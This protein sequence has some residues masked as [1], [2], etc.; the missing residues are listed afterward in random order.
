[1]WKG[2]GTT[3]P[4]ISRVNRRDSKLA[5]GRRSR[6]SNRSEHSLGTQMQA[7]VSLHW[8]SWT[9]LSLSR[10]GSRDC[11]RRWVLRRCDASRRDAVAC[12]DMGGRLKGIFSRRET[13]AV[14]PCTKRV[15]NRRPLEA[16]TVSRHTDSANTRARTMSASMVSHTMLKSFSAAVNAARV[17]ATVSSS[18]GLKVKG[19]SKVRQ[20]SASG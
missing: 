7:L 1:M 15:V 12:S 17:L 4:K 9:T 14:R 18:C 2:E 20:R 13:F 3:K 6:G 8:L 19:K 16:R 5:C 11:T 10:C